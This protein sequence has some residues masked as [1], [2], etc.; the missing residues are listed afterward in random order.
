MI[1]FTLL[2]LVI[3]TGA[4]AAISLRNLVHCTLAVTMAFAGLAAVYLQLQAEFLGFAQVMIYIGAVAILIVFAILLTR[5]IE[6]P[7]RPMAWK[8]RAAGVGVA[9]LL[10]G[11][12]ALMILSSDKTA[13]SAPAMVSPGVRQIGDQLMSRFVLPLEVLGLLLTAAM[14]GAIILAGIGTERRKE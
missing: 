4:V 12:M 3:L 13:A 9:A 6:P 14:I 1:L 2:A 11:F 10:F 5:G 7:G 8:G